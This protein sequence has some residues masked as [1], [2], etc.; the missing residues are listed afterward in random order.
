MADYTAN[1]R[2]CVRVKMIPHL[3]HLVLLGLAWFGSTTAQNL[4]GICNPTGVNGPFLASFPGQMQ[5]V[6]GNSLSSA[7]KAALVQGSYRLEIVNSDVQLSDAFDSRRVLWRA[8]AS[9]PGRTDLIMQPDGDVVLYH[10]RQTDGTQGSPTPIT[11]T[12]NRGQGPYCFL[13][14]TNRQLALYDSQCTILWAAGTTLFDRPANPDGTCKTHKVREN[15][16]CQQVADENGID[17]PMLNRY[18]NF[19]C[20]KDLALGLRLCVSLGVKPPPPIPPANPDGSCRFVEVGKDGGDCWALSKSCGPDMDLETFQAANPGLSCSNNNPTILFQYQRFCCSQGQKP[21]RRLSPQNGNCAWREADPNEFY[22]CA[23]LASRF[24]VTVDEIEA[25]NKNNWRWTGCGGMQTGARVCLSDGLPPPPK[26]NPEAQ[27]GMETVGNL[28]CPLKAC[29]GKWGYC[30]ATPDFCTEVPGPPGNGCQQNCGMTVPV[31][32]HKCGP[33]TMQI[34]VG[35]YQSWAVGRTP[36]KCR[37]YQV[38]DIVAS[39]WTHIHYAF[40]VVTED[41]RLDVESDMQRQQLTDMQRLKLQ[42]PN[43]KLIIS[44]GGW[45]FNDPPTQRRFTDMASTPQNR[46][47]FIQSSRDFLLTYRLDGLDIDWEY[48]GAD[49]RNTAPGLPTRGKEDTVNYLALIR[50]LRQAFGGWGG[51]SLSIAAPASQWYLK[52]FDIA[53]MAKELDYIVYMTYDL[54]GAWDYRI[55][56]IGPLLN[57]HNNWTEVEQTMVMVTKAGVDTSK[58]LLGIGFYARSFKL[59]D[60]ECNYPGCPWSD[61]G[62]FDGQNYPYAATPGE[63][64][65]SGGTL[66]YFEIMDMIRAGNFEDL[67][68][69]EPSKSQLLTYRGGTEWVGF[70]DMVSMGEKLKAAQELCLGGIIVWSVDQDDTDE[71]LL[72]EIEGAGN[73]ISSV[74][75]G[76]RLNIDPGGDGKIPEIFYTRL[77]DAVIDFAATH[78][79]TPADVF[80]TTIWGMAEMYEKITEQLYRRMALPQMASSEN[81]NRK[82]LTLQ[83]NDPNIQSCFRCYVSGRER[84]CPRGEEFSDGRR[85]DNMDQTE[86][87][88]RVVDGNKLRTLLGYHGINYND[89]EFRTVKIKNFPAPNSRHCMDFTCPSNELAWGGVM[90]IKQVTE[91]GKNYFTSHAYDLYAEAVR[92]SMEQELRN[93]AVGGDARA[94]WQCSGP[95]GPVACP[96]TLDPRRIPDHDITWN[97]APGMND[98]LIF[99]LETVSGVPSESLGFGD[100]QLAYSRPGIQRPCPPQF[101]GACWERMPIVQQITW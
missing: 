55:P 50:E 76:F 7:G 28:E 23:V 27:C 49:D 33:Q 53:E 10:N 79:F 61:P 72:S 59:E 2:P 25:W 35:Y 3:L 47:R 6:D 18:N 12:Q 81:G 5:S 46:A 66:A 41:F 57:A 71:S 101:P 93:T 91:N 67:T 4:C 77:R 58:I 24:D 48:P 75:A 21:S 99:V 97:V 85:H 82:L 98:E 78:R 36:G 92:P 69:D 68:Y 100:F 26:I 87:E 60:P 11:R 90:T 30:G 94:Y 16:W 45:A 56:S 88:W 86:Y 52:W 8:G 65:K 42:N 15:Q 34:R 9:G 19:D 62:I 84:T 73:D 13:L 17:L 31:D 39:K 14:A 95:R 1:G 29:C 70:D 22:S 51:W 80:K 74:L 37:Q 32:R 64:T 54:H 63:C 38:T 96:D 44:V 83:A 89:V 43:I 20:L 40:A